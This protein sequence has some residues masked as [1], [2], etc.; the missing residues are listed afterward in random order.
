VGIKVGGCVTGFSVRAKEGLLVGSA[1][2]V[3]VGSIVGSKV[4]SSVGALDGPGRQAPHEAPFASRV[5]ASFEPIHSVNASL[6]ISTPPFAHVFASVIG[7]LRDVGKA[8][9]LD[10]EGS[11]VG[12]LVGERAGASVGLSD[13]A[14]VGSAV[15]AGVGAIVVVTVGNFDGS[16]VGV[17]EG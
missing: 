9:G 3:F 8:V 14:T 16:N 17:N 13:G 6:H 11:W 10:I 2:G 5:A 7:Q 12:E 15:G 4:G 1:E